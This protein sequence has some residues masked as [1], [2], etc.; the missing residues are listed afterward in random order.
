MKRLFDI[1]IVPTI[2]DEDAKRKGFILN[3][4]L[5][6]STVLMLCAFFV[7]MAS[8]LFGALTHEQ[9]VSNSLQPLVI[10][11][12]S[13]FFIGLY[14]LSRRGFCCVASYLVLA[15]FFSLILYMNYQWGVD[16]PST[17][18]LSALIIVMSG[19]LIDTRFAFM[20]TGVISV[21]MIA[22]DYLQKNQFIAI[23]HYWRNG[24]WTVTDTIMTVVIF[25]IIATVSWLSNREIERSLARARKSETELKIERDMLEV[26]VEERTRELKESQAEKMTQVYRFAEFGRLSSGVFHDLINPLNAVSLNIEQARNRRDD[27]AVADTRV[28]LDR[29]ISSAKKMQDLIVALRGQLTQQGRDAAF[30]LTDEVGQA[31]EI[32][33]LKAS[34]AGVKIILSSDGDA[35]I[36]SFGDVTKFGQIAL[37]LIANAIDSYLPAAPLTKESVQE[38]TKATNGKNAREDKRVLVSL[39]RDGNNAILVVQDHGIGIPEE[40]HGKIF[41]PFFSTKSNGMGI[42]LSMVKRIVEKDF[43]GSIECRSTENEGSTFIIILPIKQA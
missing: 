23:N 30:S 40:N 41:E 10:F 8:I 27:A 17:I 35:A 1:I 16:L 36:D 18:L 43:D 29:A 4:L 21:S 28:C 26:K 33:M 20:A 31:V 22:V 5:V 39:K 25:V 9:Y 32:L 37:N 13:I 11:L 14:V 19:I 15:S 12:F 24:S 2:A 3:I 42:G 38:G 7:L 6:A 34:Q